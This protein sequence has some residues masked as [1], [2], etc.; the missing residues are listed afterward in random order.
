MTGLFWRATL[1]AVVGAVIATHIVADDDFRLTDQEI[2]RP[3]SNLSI[4][5]D[6]FGA[7]LL[8]RFD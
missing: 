5:V 6:D 7:G 8:N 3:A 4:V 1:V 2:F